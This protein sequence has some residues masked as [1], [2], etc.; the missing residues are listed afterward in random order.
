LKMSDSLDALAHIDELQHGA[1]G[2]GLPFDL[3]GAPPIYLASVV[4]D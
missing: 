2:S 1:G 3:C 4:S